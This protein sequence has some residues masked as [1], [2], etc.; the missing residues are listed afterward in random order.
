MNRLASKG[1]AFKR[2]ASLLV[3][4]LLAALI[5]C[6]GLAEKKVTVTFTGDITLGGETYVQKGEF[7]FSGYYKKYGAEYFLKYLR[8]L[9][10]S[11]DLTVINFEGT[12]DDNLGDENTNKVIRFHAPTSY[13]NVLTTS[14]VELCGLS[15]NH[16]L[17]FKQ[18]GINS[19]KET[20]LAAGLDYTVLYRSV[21]K[22][23]NGVKLGFISL[24]WADFSRNRHTWMQEEI[25]RLKQEEGVSAVVVSIHAGTEYDKKHNKS[26]K[27][28]ATTAVD[29]GADLVIMHHPHVLQG[30][31]IMN[32]RYVFY[33]LGNTC[34][35]GN[36]EV[37]SL[38]TAVLQVDF[39]FTDEGEYTAQQVRI[40]PAH[41]TGTYPRSNFQPILVSG[42]DAANV[43]SLIQYDT[44]FQL[45][46]FDETTG[47]VTQPLLLADGTEL[48]DELAVSAVEGAPE[49][50]GT[51]LGQ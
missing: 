9:F 41:T 10:E 34:F 50:T 40:Y 27:Y 25:K 30:C 15:N 48:T 24:Y 33:S 19:T 37:W 29:A 3:C 31:E 26:Q 1:L 7:S 47:C 16:S 43:L 39:Y 5:P 49:A 14:S 38:E 23:L 44:K 11:D 20:L 12:F 32:S 8:P 13:V 6:A 28:M 22:E 51:E 18:N 21:V 17:D 2:F 4:L 45:Q 42:T 46:P 35:G 36:N